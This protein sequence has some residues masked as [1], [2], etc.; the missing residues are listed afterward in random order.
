M[1]TIIVCGCVAEVCEREREMYLLRYIF[2]FY[3]YRYFFFD[4]GE[5]RRDPYLLSF[6]I[7]VVTHLLIFSFIQCGDFI[8]ELS[9]EQSAL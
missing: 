3:R 4:P 9:D 8:N 6:H 5:M 7:T 1:H 2:F